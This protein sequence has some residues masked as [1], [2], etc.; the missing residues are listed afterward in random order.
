VLDRQR[1]NGSVA[2]S[3]LS[4]DLYYGGIDLSYPVADWLTA[5]VGYAYTDTDRFSERRLFLIDGDNIPPAVGALRPDLLLGDAVIDFFDIGLSEPTQTDPAFDAG[6]EINAGYVK[7]NIEPVFGVSVDLGVRYE[8]AVQTVSTVQ[9]FENPFVSLA[10]TLIENDYFLPGLTVTWEATDSLQFRASASQT[11]ARPQFRELIFQPFTDPDNQRQFIG[12]PALIDS[13]LVNAEVRAEYYFGRGNRVTAAGFYK[14]IDNPIE[15]YVSIGADTSFTTRF[16]NAPKAELFGGE[17]E[18]QWTKPLFDWGATGWLESKEIILATNYTYTQSE[19]QVGA[20]DVTRIFTAGVGA[21]ENDADLFFING[22]PL[23]G[24]S[25]HLVNLQ[26]GIEDQD[27]LQQLT[28]LMS[29][30]SERVTRR[31]T[32]GLP[33][34]VEDPGLN[35]DIVLR[36]ELDMFSVPLELKAEARNIFGRGNFEFQ[37]AGGNRIEVNSFDVG[38]SFSLGLKAKF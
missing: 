22:D 1:G 5:T 18:F 25:D 28:F 26:L 35:F 14:E 30:A 23:T 15:P 12:N 37:E 21:I 20:G 3:E 13:E 33:D 11:I 31:G 9:R 34:I 8:D 27:K 36:Q 6:L 29:F 2:F 38:T 32:A 7:L 17:F 16:A 10:N 4:E 24:Q 19:L